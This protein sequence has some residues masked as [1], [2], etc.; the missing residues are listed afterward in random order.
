MPEQKM[1]SVLELAKYHVGEDVWWV[2]LRPIK[3]KCQLSNNQKWMLETHPQVLYE[4][5]YKNL[6]S[7][8]IVLPKLQHMDFA[9]IM[10]LLTSDIRVESFMIHKI[11]RSRNTGQFFYVN[12][13]DEC[14]QERSLFR[15]KHVASLE[16]ARV[17]KMIKKWLVLQDK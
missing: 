8:R 2:I 10:E 1:K 11:I 15:S 4:G 17:L 14:S 16:R 6:W 3:S 13:S 9:N 12:E 5:P 7:N